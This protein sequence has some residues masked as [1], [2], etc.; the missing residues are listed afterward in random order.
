MSPD[1]PLVIIV[2]VLGILS[3]LIAL[4]WAL[5]AVMLWYWKLDKIV[6]LLEEIKKVLEKK[7]V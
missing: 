5:R 7:S 6:S 2:Y 3:L 4:F 1:S